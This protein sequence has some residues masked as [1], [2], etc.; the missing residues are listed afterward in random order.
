[1]PAVLLE[2]A[3][4]TNAED[5]ARIADPQARRQMMVAVGDAVDAFFTAPA[6][7]PPKVLA[8]TP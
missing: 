2:M 6:D 3:F 5:E 7:N 8:R 1:M 4:L